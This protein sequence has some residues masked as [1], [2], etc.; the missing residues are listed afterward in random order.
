MI[1]KH[2]KVV[3]GKG[4]PDRTPFMKEVPD[5][6]PFRIVVKGIIELGHTCINLRLTHKYVN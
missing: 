1:Y 5:R 2:F 6:T 3:F 4:V